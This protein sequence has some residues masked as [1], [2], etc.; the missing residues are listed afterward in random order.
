MGCNY[1][2]LPWI[3]ASGTTLPYY[4]VVN[5]YRTKTFHSIISC[6]SEQQPVEQTVELL[7]K[8]NAL[9]SCC[10]CN[11]HH[12]NTCQHYK[13]TTHIDYNITAVNGLLLNQ[14]ETLLRAPHSSNDNIYWGFMQYRYKIMKYKSMINI[15]LGRMVKIQTAITIY[16][17]GIMHRGPYMLCYGLL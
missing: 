11:M 4:V 3:P 15:H 12:F 7:L 1:L 8:S 2:S 5:K 6:A 14:H 10:R 13:P 9:E 17:P 16:H